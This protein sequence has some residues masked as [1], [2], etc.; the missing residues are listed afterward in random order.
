MKKIVIDT[1]AYTRLLAGDQEIL[2]VLAQAES[3][4][5]PVFVMGELLAGFRGGTRESE[6]RKLLDDFLGRE[7]VL[8]VPATMKTA[9]IFAELK[10]RLKKA[11]KPIPINDVWIAAQAMETGAFLVTYDKH[12]KQITG[13][14]L[15]NIPN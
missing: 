12:F 4:Y 15:W 5:L 14:L 6:N 8:L 10:H 1:N 9:E 3:V 11:G 7:I 2:K 13:L